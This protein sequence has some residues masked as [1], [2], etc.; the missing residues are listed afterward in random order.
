[1]A[2]V[3]VIFRSRF[4]RRSSKVILDGSEQKSR[5]EFNFLDIVVDNSRWL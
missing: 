4:F 1:M 3:E 2:L 5:P